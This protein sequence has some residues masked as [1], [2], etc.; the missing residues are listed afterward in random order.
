MSNDHPRP[1]F[2][3]MTEANALAY[4]SWLARGYSTSVAG[5]PISDHPDRQYGAV[6][7][8]LADGTTATVWMEDGRMYGEA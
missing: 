5:A 7:Y 4:A 6:V 2:T 3:E 1:H 8:P